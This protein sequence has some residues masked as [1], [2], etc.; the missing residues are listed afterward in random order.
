MEELAARPKQPKPTG[1]SATQVHYDKTSGKWWKAFCKEA[2]WD[3]E[4]KRV[5]IDDE[6]NPVDGTFRRFFVWCYEQ[7]GMSCHIF[8]A[9]LAWAQRE[10]NRQLTAQMKNLKPW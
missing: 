1:S 9:L 6:C 4:A 5:F 2:Q 10:L 7:P 8:K 3:M